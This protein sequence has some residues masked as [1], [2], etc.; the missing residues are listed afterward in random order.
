MRVS[1]IPVAP[2]IANQYE[3]LPAASQQTIQKLL[4]IWLQRYSSTQGRSLSDLMDQASDT[5]EAN[6]LTD[7]ILKDILDDES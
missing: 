5:A 2:E 6:G 4:G 3:Q 1:S 7:E